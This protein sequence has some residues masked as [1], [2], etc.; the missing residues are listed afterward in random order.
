MTGLQPIL[1]SG[2]DPTLF[3]ALVT[4]VLGGG[5]WQAV[6]SFR[7]AGSEAR[8]TGSEADSIASQTLIAVN[9][10]LRLEISRRDAE[11][12]ELRERVAVLEAASA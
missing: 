5:L 9:A 11:I 4:G 7:K 10:E 2:I 1:L 6:A 8:K 12:R 3:A